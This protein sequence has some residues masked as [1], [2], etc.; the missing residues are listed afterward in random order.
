MGTS[1]F[2][3]EKNVVLI[4]TKL[5]V[6]VFT[7]FIRPDGQRGSHLICQARKVIKFND[8][9]FKNVFDYHPLK[10]F[11]LIKTTVI[12]QIKKSLKT[13]VAIKNKQNE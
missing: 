12:L 9:L 2:F 5:Q 6:I 1:K 11:W 10:L 4:K 13:S 7:L 3:T 8:E